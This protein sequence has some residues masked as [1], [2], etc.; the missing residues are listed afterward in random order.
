MRDMQSPQL[1]FLDCE[2][3]DSIN[4]DLI[5]IGLVSEDGQ[6]SFYA[7]RSDFEQ[8]WC[9]PAVRA[10]IHPLLDG[11][12]VVTRVDLA[13]QLR[14][15]FVELSAQVEIACDDRTD[16][17]LLL[18]AL[19]GYL[20]PNVADQPRSLR[21]LTDSPAFNEAVRSFHSLPN[22]PWHQAL[23]DVHAHRAGWVAWMNKN[24]KSD[25]S[26]KCQTDL[27]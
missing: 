26:E 18:D 17:D 6:H 16:W 24:A 11:S 15:W 8:G 2:Y 4:C 1:V 14:S 23:H 22:H 20:P 25:L 21:H 12:N 10:G 3:I 19:D 13:Q 7:E 27:L 5:S 9:N